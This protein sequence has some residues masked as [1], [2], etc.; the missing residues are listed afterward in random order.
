MRIQC[1]VA[2]LMSF[3]KLLILLIIYSGDFLVKFNFGRLI[4][5][6]WEYKM[7]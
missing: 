1:Q 4:K 5:L 6:G 3:G 7:G 2:L